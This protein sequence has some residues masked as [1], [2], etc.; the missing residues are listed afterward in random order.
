MVA[1]SAPPPGGSS[2]AEPLRVSVAADGTLAAIHESPRITLVEVPSGAA[3]AE[4]GVDPDALGSEVAWVCT[5]PRLLVLAR[6]AAHS[7]IHL[8]DPHGPR[9]LAEIRL[10]APMR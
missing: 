2:S 3:F 4:I 9:S 1:R 7:T 5:P 8:L 10:P 6:H